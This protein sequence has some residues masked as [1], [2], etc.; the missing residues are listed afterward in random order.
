MLT[1]RFLIPF[2]ATVWVGTT[3]GAQHREHRRPT[4]QGERRGSGGSTIEFKGG[5][6][7]HRIEGRVSRG[8][9]SRRGQDAGSHLATGRQLRPVNTVV[10]TPRYIPRCTT[11]PNP[12]YWQRRDIMAEIQWM[13]R[14]GLVGVTPVPEDVNELNGA[15]DY[16]AGWK[17]YGFVVP[18]G[19]KLHV[20]LH[21]TNEGWFRLA[22]VNKWGDL[23]A[24][25]L[26][27]LIPTG[28][29]EV[30]YTNPSKEPQAVYVIVDDPGWMSSKAYPFNLQV[31]RDW[32]P[33]K[34][35]TQG[36]KMVEGIWAS[37][38]GAGASAEFARPSGHASFGV[39]LR[40]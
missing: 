18:A 7:A 17:A 14:R 22:M 35:D 11:Q 32:E 4:P 27:N 8:E 34:A 10:V 23:S 28:N 1:A 26:Q 30:R 38:S 25:M 12:H 6:R 36:V 33:G 24:G 5:D 21:H 15:S 13:S 20:R 2:L 37:N 39:G 16:P 9:P 31:Q 40:W 29:P 19:G 3:L